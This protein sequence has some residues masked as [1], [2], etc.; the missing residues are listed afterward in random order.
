[1]QLVVAAVGQRMP[2]WVQQ[3]WTEYARRL[4]RELSLELREIPLAK[5]SRNAPTAKA[6][7]AEGV[8]L[9][10]AIPPGHR[11][12]A[13]DE[14]GRQWSTQ[15]LASRLED[16]MREERGVGFMIGGPDGLSS[17]CRS[18]A[19]DTWALGKLTLPHPLVRVILAEQLY[20]AWT[21]T[22][23]HPYHRA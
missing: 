16:W 10:A 20:R 11:T 6:R 15:D 23:N 2:A 3:A 7:A 14:R 5:R 1:M 13:L 4:P 17:D 12:I 9:L 19:Q 18:H 8:K 22:C 21:I